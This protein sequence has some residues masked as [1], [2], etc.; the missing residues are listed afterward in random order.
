MFLYFERIVSSNIRSQR[1]CQYL[2]N[3]CKK[4]QSKHFNNYTN[5]IKLICFIGDVLY[6]VRKS[7]K[8]NKCTLQA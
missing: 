3:Y 7:I 6:I 8:N 1:D 5:R 2:Q 4:L